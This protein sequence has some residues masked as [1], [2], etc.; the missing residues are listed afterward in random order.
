[1][2]LLIFDKVLSIIVITH[3]VLLMLKIISSLF[4]LI[5]F[6]PVSIIRQNAAKIV[7]DITPALFLE[8]SVI[9][10]S[11]VLSYLS[12]FPTLGETLSALVSIEFSLL[13][14]TITPK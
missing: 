12:I 4:E 7:L 11:L 8:H 14:H 6:T 9:W 3:I 13:S 5:L 1:M 10:F 2:V